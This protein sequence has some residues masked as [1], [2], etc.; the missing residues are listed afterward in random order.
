MSPPSSEADIES[1]KRQAAERALELVEDGMSIGIGTRSTMKYFIEGLGRK[2]AEGLR[3]QGLPT[4]DASA[5]LAIAAGIPLLSKPCLL[6]LAFDGADEIAP[7]L[8]LIK[9]GGGALLREKLVA[10]SARGLVVIADDSKLVD[11]L[12]QGVLPVDIV[13][14]LWQETARRVGGL[15]VT[16]TLRGGEATPF[17]TDDG[18]LI[19]DVLCPGGIANPCQLAAD[20]KSQLGVVEHGLFL[21]IAI[22]CVVAGKAGVRVLGRVVP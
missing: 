19:L 8:G 6:D 18:N 10:S 14:F 5:K 13:P 2:V 16:W 12:G 17:R 3:V 1:Y 20:L 15:G 22:G 9:G 11:R 7:D 21:G 4:S